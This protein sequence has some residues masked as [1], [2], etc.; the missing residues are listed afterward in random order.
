AAGGAAGGAP[1]AADALSA[2]ELDAW[3]GFL[4]AHAALTRELDEELE[5][6]EGLSLTEYDVLVQLA[7]FPGGSLRMSE[8]ADA[9]L[10]SRSGL[11]RL[12]DDLERR[13]LVERTRC[14]EDARGLNAVITERG[15]EQRRRAAATHL[16]GVRR[17]FHRRLS[18]DQ[19]EGLRRA[20]RAL[21]PD[22]VSRP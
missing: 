20:W 17:R 4:R 18:E 14:P 22:A 19:L 5:R 9:V 12:V 13:G 1:A 11:T 16:E 8:L 21:V 15:R 6:G 3:R 10:L 2:L 7:D